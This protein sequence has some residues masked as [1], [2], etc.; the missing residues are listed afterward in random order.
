MRRVQGGG[1]QVN[2]S[3]ALLLA[4]SCF[5]AGCAVGFLLAGCA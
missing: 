3:E 2:Y 4:A 5:I 1:M